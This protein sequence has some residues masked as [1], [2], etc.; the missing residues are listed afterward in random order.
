MALSRASKPSVGGVTL[1]AAVIVRRPTSPV[2]NNQRTRSFPFG[3]E[4]W[5]PL[6]GYERTR[7]PFT[8]LFQ[9]CQVKT[10]EL[11]CRTS[12]RG[13]LCALAERGRSEVKP[14]GT[15]RVEAGTRVDRFE[16]REGTLE[17]HVLHL[18]WPIELQLC[19]TGDA[20]PGRGARGS[21]PLILLL[22]SQEFALERGHSLKWECEIHI[23]APHKTEERSRG[24]V[25]LSSGE[26]R[27]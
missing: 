21:I 19:A 24:A 20:A 27:H 6:P 7:G 11:K 15:A 22:T 14:G 13:A 2:G 18:D 5:I 25:L 1:H 10:E 26:A 17:F 16:S 8:F 9:V 3:F 23:A 4:R 12:T